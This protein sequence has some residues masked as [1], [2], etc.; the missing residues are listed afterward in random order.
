ME[1]ADV[2]AEA[3]QEATYLAWLDCSGL[4]LEKAAVH[5]WMVQARPESAPHRRFRANIDRKSSRMAV[6]GLE[7]GLNPLNIRPLGS[8]FEQFKSAGVMATSPT[9]RLFNTL[10]ATMVAIL[11][12]FICVRLQMLVPGEGHL[13][14]SECV[15]WNRGAYIDSIAFAYG[16]SYH[17]FNRVIH[18]THIRYII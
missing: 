6:F 10:L 1:K 13:K 14:G 8:E 18:T 11:V 7:F 17:I 4:P 2:D 16:P 5:S 9:L 15:R 3:H 12:G